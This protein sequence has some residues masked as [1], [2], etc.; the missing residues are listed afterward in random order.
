MGTRATIRVKD[1]HD[2]FFMY[3]QFD[4]APDM[5]L[6]KLIKEFVKYA[7]TIDPHLDSYVDRPNA[8][9]TKQNI[10]NVGAEACKFVPALLGYLW[11]HDYTSV[12]LHSN[13]KNW[14]EESVH[15]EI[16][17]GWGKKD[18]IDLEIEDNYK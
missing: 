17:L 16:T 13:R 9:G 8:I 15:Y 5:Q 4:G 18:Q 14:E 10:P 6:G 1:E 3:C 12:Y 11:E 7:P 2:E